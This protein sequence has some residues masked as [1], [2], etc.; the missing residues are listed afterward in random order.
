MIKLKR[1][2]EAAST[3]DGYR[4]LV[5]RVW[6]RGMKKSNLPLDEW[7][8]D[9]APS[10]SLPKAFG[11]DP[12]RW[13]DFRTSYLEEL[14]AKELKERIHE[15]ASACSQIYNDAHLFSS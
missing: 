4:I 14:Q 15:L 11:H 7:A 8:K 13:N 12:A 1:A 6:P 5:D 10:A 2:Y 9:L 3:E